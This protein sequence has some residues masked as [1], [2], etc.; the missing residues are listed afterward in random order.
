MVKALVTVEGVGNMLEPGI[1]IPSLARKPVQGIL[2]EQFNPLNILKDIILVLP[3]MVDIINISPLIL[4]EG[5]KS[6]E[7]NLKKPSTGQL[8]GI[9]NSFLAGFCLIAATILVAFDGPWPLW[10]FLFFLAIVL[11]LRK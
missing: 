3:E 11:A 1:N 6:F 4:S 2:L 5:L 7:A 10:A 8:D 9:R